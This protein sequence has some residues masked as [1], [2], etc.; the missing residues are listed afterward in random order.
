MA[1]IDSFLRL[2]AEQ[3]ASD[4]HFHS[5]VAPHIRHEGDLVAL[6]FRPLTELDTKRF[7]YELMT[8]EQRAA[9]EL[10]READFAYEVADAGRFRV[11][12]FVQGRGM[13]A[14]FRI[15]PRHMPT[16]EE[17][18]L[19]PVLRTLG[20]QQNGLVLVTGPTG[21]GKTTSLAALVNDI[22]RNSDR[23]VI[24]I[25]DP[26]EF[27][28]TPVKSVI[29]QR[30]VGLHAESF[31]S[32]LRS[33]LREAPDV[34]IVGELRDRETVGLALT[35][36]ETGVLVFGTLHTN[37]A[38]KAVDR[39]LGV[40]M[41][42]EQA[43]AVLAS[44]LRGVVAQHLCKRA[45]G[46]G[47]VA[48]LEI[49]LSTHALSHLIREGK[50]HLIEQYLQSGEH[51]ALGGQSLDGCILAYVREGIITLEEGVKVANDPAQLRE[52]AARSLADDAA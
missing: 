22:N 7:L 41:E 38:A 16:L 44:V 25:E 23:H 1:R 13:G 12:V 46:E 49:L 36:A 42:D 51:L 10:H 5:G 43:R 19:P 6:P 3:N 18:R 8:A 24:T 4:L 15:I 52:L 28:H 26:I 34:V 37:S 45:S 27:V 20:D 14:V 11:N 33:A 40:M 47:L 17:L 32:A 31:A 29:T 2:V 39:I 21:S 50:L 30:Q 9:F 48:V 35:A